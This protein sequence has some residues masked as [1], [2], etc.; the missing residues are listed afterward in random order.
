MVNFLLRVFGRKLLHILVSIKTDQ[1]LFNCLKKVLNKN[2][3]LSELKLGKFNYL[4]HINPTT[5]NV[6]IF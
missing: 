5:L 3:F 4:T 6:R 1:K 2:R